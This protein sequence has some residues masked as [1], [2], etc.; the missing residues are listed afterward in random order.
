[1]AHY[2]IYRPILMKINV[3]LS[4]TKYIDI[5]LKEIKFLMMNFA[6][7]VNFRQSHSNFLPNKSTF[8]YKVRYQ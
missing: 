1:M 7:S 4:K 8:E 5:Y 3:Y 2:G 6:G